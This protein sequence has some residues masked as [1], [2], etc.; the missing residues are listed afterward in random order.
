MRINLINKKFGKLIVLEELLDRHP[1]TR[2][3]M[4]KCKC[5]CGNIKNIS[6]RHLIIGKTKSCGCNK[7]GMNRK[8]KETSYNSLFR[9]Y[10]RNALK[11]NRVFL[12]TI[13]QFK[14][15]I[16]KNCHYCGIPPIRDYN[17]LL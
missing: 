2:G 6:G 9:I 12:L 14:D 13:N 16:N 17:P 5:D 8:D 1:S 3:I 15:L 7:I 10:K 11:N 4:W